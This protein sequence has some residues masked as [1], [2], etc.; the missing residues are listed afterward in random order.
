MSRLTDYSK[1]DHIEC[2]DD[3]TE[4]LPPMIDKDSFKKYTKA[5]R[6]QRD[7]GEEKNIASLQA[8]I[9][10]AQ[11]ELKQLGEVGRNHVKGKKLAEQLAE[12]EA[13]LAKLERTYG[14]RLNANKLSADVHSKTVILG[15]QLNKDVPV[16][17]DNV[18]TEQFL[19]FATKNE[20]LLQHD[21]ETFV[22][23][24]CLQREQNRILAASDR[25]RG[26][27][28]STSSE[29]TL[30]LKLARRTQL[31]TQALTL[32]KMVRTGDPNWRRKVEAMEGGPLEAGE[33]GGKTLC[34]EEN[35]IV[36]NKKAVEAMYER[37]TTALT[38]AEDRGNGGK[39]E[40]QYVELKASFTQEVDAFLERI[41]KRARERIAEEEDERMENEKRLAEKEQELAAMK[42]KSGKSD[43][44]S[45][46]ASSG[47]GRME[48]ES[49]GVRGGGK[50]DAEKQ[51]D[52]CSTS[53]S[54]AESE[55]GDGMKNPD[56]LG[57][58]GLTAQEVFDTL[59][60]QLQEAFLEQDGAKLK[61]AFWSLPEKEL[62]KHFKRCVASGLWVPQEGGDIDLRP[63]DGAGIGDP[64]RDSDSD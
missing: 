47:G 15:Q 60:P 59:P 25:D 29:T 51:A 18:D 52:Q 41:G 33:Q 39:K 62:Q 37:L 32:S 42:S 54:A 55:A 19:S 20:Q 7:T 3:D 13:R 4:D 6:E 27:N 44:G 43:G 22:M 23:L 36:V 50:N 64:S 38:D 49:G 46:S 24:E 5:K 8:K 53:C 40:S 10:R 56:E 16:I 11:R 57:P 26:D 21:A 14:R 17:D 35:P 1:W 12:D 31:I 61:Q 28:S 2:S 45:A 48:L 9:A 34:V 63:H 30:I 58:G